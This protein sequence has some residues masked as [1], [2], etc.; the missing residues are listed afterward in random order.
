MKA[1]TSDDTVFRTRPDVRFRVVGDEAIVVRQEDAEVIALNE[2]GA[3]IL[4]LLDSRRSV[5]DLLDALLEEY[6]VDR[7]SLATD[8]TR[9][10]RE[11]RDAGV[12]EPV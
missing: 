6:D 8:L 1:V 9:F 10:L 3:T 5:R 11:L 4:G 12:V 7:D 2:I